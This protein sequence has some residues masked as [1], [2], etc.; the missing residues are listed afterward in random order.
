MDEGRQADGKFKPGNPGNPNG[1]PGNAAK[2][3]R[4]LIER[5]TSDEEF[6]AGWKAVKEAVA[7]GDMKAATLFFERL[8]GKPVQA[9]ELSGQDGGALVVTFKKGEGGGA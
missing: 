6:L 4:A 3:F 8:L 9:V 2:H 7:S 5:N 1:N